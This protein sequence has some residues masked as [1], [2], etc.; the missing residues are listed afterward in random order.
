[1][2]FYQ[3]GYPNNGYQRNNYQTPISNYYPSI[4]QQSYSPYQIDSI[5]ARFVD[6]EEEARSSTV[7]PGQP[8]L[9]RNRTC[10]MIYSK[11]IDPNTGAM[12]FRCFCEMKN[13]AENQPQYV[14]MEMLTNFQSDIDKRFDSINKHLRGEDQG[15]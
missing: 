4:A 6:S 1:M 13:Q 15:V 7:M 9:F 8:F 11:Y 2:N 14:T 10:G 3:Q 5:Q 12:D